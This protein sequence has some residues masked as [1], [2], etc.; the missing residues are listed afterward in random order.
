M[1]KIT[2]RE[3]IQMMMSVA[4]VSKIQSHSQVKTIGLN[5]LL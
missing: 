2:E 3:I 1:E 4:V 5:E